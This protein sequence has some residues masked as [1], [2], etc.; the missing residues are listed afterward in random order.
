MSTGRLAVQAGAGALLGYL[1]WDATNKRL[2]VVQASAA[3]G[4]DAANR[5]VAA[6]HDG[7]L[8]PAFIPRSAVADAIAEAFAGVQSLPLPGA[9]TLNQAVA[10]LNQIL[11]ILKGE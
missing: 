10:T 4:P 8:D 6:G 11:A 2:A 3:G 5:I 7:V 1:V 9:A